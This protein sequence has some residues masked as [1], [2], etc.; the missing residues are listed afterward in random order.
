MLAASSL[1]EARVGPTIVES[2][3]GE[4]QRI[5]DMGEEVWTNY[6]FTVFT[7]FEKGILHT[8]HRE[9]V[10][11]P[12]NN[13]VLCYVDA[14]KLTYDNQFGS[15]QTLYHDNTNVDNSVKINKLKFALLVR[16]T[17]Q[18]MKDN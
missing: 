18:A 13:F 16:S 9:G 12:S 8:H 14:A 2:F 17:I 10:E 15:S 4:N 6:Q 1:W 7:A 5:R 11:R 3:K